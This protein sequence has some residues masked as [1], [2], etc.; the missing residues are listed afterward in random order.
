MSMRKAT[1]LDRGRQT[2]QVLL[3]GVATIPLY[4]NLAFEQVGR[5][6]GDDFAGQ[7]AACAI[8]GS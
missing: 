7:A 2:A 8:G 4:A 5:H 1:Y 6:I 3:G